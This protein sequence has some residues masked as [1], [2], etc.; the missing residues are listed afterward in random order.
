MTADVNANPDWPEN[1][2]EIMSPDFIRTENIRIWLAP[3]VKDVTDDAKKKGQFCRYAPDIRQIG[4][5]TS[6]HGHCAGGL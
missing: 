5:L 6:Q 1:L 2:K 4:A 3:D